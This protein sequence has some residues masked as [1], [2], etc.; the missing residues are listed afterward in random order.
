LYKSGWGKR[1]EIGVCEKERDEWENQKT[2]KKG[3]IVVVLV[4]LG[5]RGRLRMRPSNGDSSFLI[6]QWCTHNKKKKKT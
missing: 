3:E 5:G 1:G 6:Q 4:F 2:G